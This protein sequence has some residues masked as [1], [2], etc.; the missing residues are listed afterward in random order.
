MVRTKRVL[1]EDE[2]GKWDY[3]MSCYENDRHG[4]WE[5]REMK[6]EE[7]V[8]FWVGSQVSMMD[9]TEEKQKKAHISFD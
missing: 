9:D 2:K 5:T 6:W 7:C 1:C 3:L 4:L 8:I